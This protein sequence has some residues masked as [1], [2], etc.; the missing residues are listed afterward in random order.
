MIIWLAS[1][2][3]SGNTMTRKLLK[4]AFGLGSLSI[5]KEKGLQIYP[6]VTP[7]VPAATEFADFYQAASESEKGYLVKTHGPPMDGSPAIHITRDG[8]SSVVSYYHYVRDIHQRRDSLRRIINGRVGMG[9]WSGLLDKWDPLNRPRTLLLRYEDILADPDRSIEL[10]SKFLK[11]ATTGV[12]ENNFSEMHKDRPLFFRAGNNDK[13][14]AELNWWNQRLFWK[15]HRQW[16]EKLGYGQKEYSFRSAITTL[17]ETSP[18][19]W[20]HGSDQQF[21]A[22]KAA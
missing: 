12:W 11:L 21:Y 17:P 6:Q 2:P 1:Y 7:D 5:Y 10:I 8:R 9:S 19:S 22:P 18:A 4:E 14:I 3:R 20:Y 16:M 15:K 13:N